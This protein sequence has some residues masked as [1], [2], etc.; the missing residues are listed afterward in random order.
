MSRFTVSP[1][2]KFTGGDTVVQKSYRS[3]L[4]FGDIPEGE[5]EVVKPVWK[6]KLPLLGSGE[7][8]WFYECRPKDGGPN[9]EIQEKYLKGA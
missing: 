5:L 2:P 3:N 9:I 4:K 8:R 7:N 6:K 1:E